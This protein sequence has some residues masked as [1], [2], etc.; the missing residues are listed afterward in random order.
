MKELHPSKWKRFNL[1]AKP[2]RQSLLLTPV[3]WLLTLKWKL[4]NRVKVKKVNTQ[5]LKPPYIL[6][7][8]HNAFMDYLTM[9]LAIM[10]HR[11]NYVVSVDGYVGFADILKLMGGIGKRKFT[12][13]MTLFKQLKTVVN[14][15]DIIVIYPEAR[16]SLCGTRAV[17]PDAVAKFV[18][19]L[20]VP[21]VTLNNTGH[22]INAPSWN[23]KPRGVKVD[24]A[25]M[26]KLLSVDDLEK[27][28]ISEI[29]FKI[30]NALEYD[31]YK[32]QKENKIKVTKS[33]RAEGLHRLLYQCCNCKHENEMQSEGT[34]L[35]CLHCGSSWEMTE[36]G[37]LR[38]ESGET[39]FSHIPDWYEWMREN[40][41][42]EVVGGTY[43]S[44]FSV[45][46][47]AL[48]NPK[49][50]YD[51]GE[52]T[53]VH[54]KNGFLMKWNYMGED[55]ELRKE[56]ATMYSC[57]IEYNY[58]KRHRD[59]FDLSTLDDT[60]F[61]YPNNNECSVTKLALATEEL[62]KHYIGPIET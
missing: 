19:L 21:V 28:S 25:V 27:M 22:H 37:E 43:K 41:R 61:V 38:S 59:C 2:R 8:N 60:Y 23:P 1:N 47:D 35:R 18:K 49:E 50:W 56:V 58:H 39:I 46:I 16:Y 33:D 17:I 42:E 62:Y 40:V 20:K 11:A 53:V 4:T 7:P 3:T 12:N 55:Y 15:K 36:Y 32:W 52:G 48:P 54:D 6:L 5:G 57:H 26:T 44:E 9:T 13:D 14:N 30:R 31:D 10:P 51:L 29:G 45:T 34:K 24:P